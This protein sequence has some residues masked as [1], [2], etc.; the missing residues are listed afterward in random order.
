[1]DET[2]PI[3]WL[4]GRVRLFD[5]SSDPSEQRDVSGERPEEARALGEEARMWLRSLPR[6]TTPGE[7]TRVTVDEEERRWLKAL[8]YIR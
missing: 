1:M 4:D 8:G 7:S 6:I 2:K 3:E 5:R